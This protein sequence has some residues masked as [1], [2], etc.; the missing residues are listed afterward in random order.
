MIT[1]Q[2]GNRQ[3]L[4]LIVSGLGAFA[5]ATP[6]QPPPN[7]AQLNAQM[8]KVVAGLRSAITMTKLKVGA[9]VIGQG[10]LLSLIPLLG[11]FVGEAASDSI[12]ALNSSLNSMTNVT[13][14]LDG[15]DRTDVLAGRLD[16]LKWLAAAKI[17]QQGIYDIGNT[18]KDSGPATN[19]WNTLQDA[20][21][22]IKQLVQ[23]AGD[24][25]LDTLGWLKWALPLTLAGG[26]AIAILLNPVSHGVL[27][28]TQKAGGAAKG[29]AKA[30]GRAAQAALPVKTTTEAEPRLGGMS[31]RRRRRPARRA[32]RK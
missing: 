11:P 13:N 28:V 3:Q 21:K 1:I 20:E 27:T 31:S 14:R 30:A 22:Q 19:L 10:A 9:T 24:A 6:T 26:I 32:R 29:A 23:K 25:A 15:P 7:T 8:D 16:P 17:L 2:T 18:V 12:D 4:P 5:D